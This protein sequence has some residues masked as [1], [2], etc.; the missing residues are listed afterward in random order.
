MIDEKLVSELST[1]SIGN[2]KYSLQFL[3]EALQLLSNNKYI[4][5]KAKK[6]KTSYII[7]IVHNLLLKYYFK[8]EN[9]FSLSSIV[10]K[11]KYGYLYNFYIDYLKEGKILLMEKNYLKGR[12]SRIYS[13]SEEII[14]N[15]IFRYKN[16]DKTLIKKYVQKHKIYELD[17]N[18]L[19]S[20]E[21]KEQL[22]RDLHH[23]SIQTDRSIFY[24]D[25]LRSEDIDI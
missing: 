9:S 11:D 8:K 1:P 16:E 25:S 2:K 17:H 14:N 12:N 15:K 6:L 4:E 23:V 10:L 3:P 13:L 19:I 5:Y 21:I 24:L 18:D 7:D 22:I 20:R